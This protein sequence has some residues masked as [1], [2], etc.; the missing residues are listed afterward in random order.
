MQNTISYN[1]WGAELHNGN[2]YVTKLGEERVY[3]VPKNNFGLEAED[4]KIGY[5]TIRTKLRKYVFKFEDNNLFVGDK[6][7]NHDNHL[8]SIACHIFGE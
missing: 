5:F 2:L 6:F 4:D 1:G 7:D 3:S 8:D